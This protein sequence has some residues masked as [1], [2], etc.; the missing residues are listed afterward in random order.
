LL[1]TI[2]R[3]YRTDDLD[4]LYAI[5]LTTGLAGQD[6]S[7]IF[8]DP[9]L[10][11]H[12]YAAPYASL[13]SELTWVAVDQFGVCGYVVGVED[14]AIWESELEQQWWPNLRDSYTNPED[15]RHWSPDESHIRMIFQPV[16]TPAHVCGAY[17]AHVHLNLLPRAQGKGIGAKLLRHWLAAATALGVEAV[18]VAVS[19]QNDGGLRFWRRQGFFEIERHRSDDWTVWMGRRTSH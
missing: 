12:I 2:I 4:S 8:E 13:K 5:S 9:S 10:I 19:R 18:H 14:T 15:G 11:G 6:A 16:R 7:S 3:P 17:P 1:K